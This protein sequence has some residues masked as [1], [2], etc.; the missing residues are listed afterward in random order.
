MKSWLLRQTEAEVRR[1]DTLYKFLSVIGDTLPLGRVLT[2][3]SRLNTLHHT[4]HGRV[5]Q[6]MVV[7]V[8]ERWLSRQHRVLQQ[9]VCTRR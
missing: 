1:V 8:K 3:A 7:D 6:L 4:H 5:A 9:H 2:V